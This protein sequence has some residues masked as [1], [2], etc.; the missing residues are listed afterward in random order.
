MSVSRNTIKKDS[1]P[2]LFEKMTG[3]T[4]PTY[5][6][7]GSFA[8]A[9]FHGTF[10]EARVFRVKL[11]MVNLVKKTIPCCRNYSPYYEILCAVVDAPCNTEESPL[12]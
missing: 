3:Q 11:C 5:A 4:F 1:S 6:S 12:D 7:T 10:T 2:C 8:R 9:S